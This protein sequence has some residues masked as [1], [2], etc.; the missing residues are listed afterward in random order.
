MLR[1]LPP[2]F[3]RSDVALGALLESHRLGRIELG[4]GACPLPA[5]DRVDTREQELATGGGVFACLCEAEGMHRPE[6]HRPSPAIAHK[7]EHPILCASRGNPQ[8]EP[9]AIG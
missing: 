3:M 1:V 2:S 4:L 7:P 6:P 8:I 9:S 5:L